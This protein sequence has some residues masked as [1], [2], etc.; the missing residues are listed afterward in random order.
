MPLW[1][2]GSH[3]RA[4]ETG[5]EALGMGRPPRIAM[6]TRDACHEQHRVGDRLPTSCRRDASPRP[7]TP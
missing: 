5:G 3:P 1:R 2:T 6:Q 4:W 7:S